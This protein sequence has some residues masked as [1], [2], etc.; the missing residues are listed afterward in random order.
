M[1]I[2]VENMSVTA[3]QTFLV[4]IPE[5]AG[6]MVFGLALIA[7]AVL[8]RW[9]LGRNEGDNHDEGIEKKA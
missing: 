5:T 4:S 8:I 3:L 7:V 9:L 2:L 6:L 1:M